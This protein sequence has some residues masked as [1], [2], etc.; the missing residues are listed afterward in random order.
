[1][2]ATFA[3]VTVT[4]GRV[5]MSSQSGP[6][7]L[8]VLDHAHALKLG[9]S[10]FVSIGNARRRHD[11]RPPAVVGG[12]PA[13]GRRLAARRALRRSAHV[14]PHGAAGIGPQAACRR[15]SRPPQQPTAATAW[16][17]RSSG[18]P[19]SSARRRSRNSSIWRC[20]SRPSRSR[21]V[22]D[23][24]DRQQRRR[25]GSAGGGSARAHGL[26]IANCM[27]PPC[28][29]DPRSAPAGRSTS[30]IPIDLTPH[31]RRRALPQRADS[32]ARG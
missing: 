6:L 1:M 2:A 32:R 23:V 8:A 27:T 9:L 14:R 28:S 15:S 31:A 17:T 12:R 7:G 13:D 18:R 29:C 3:P 16:S 30:P 26:R 5:A 19:A 25:S 20:C 22:T 10:G 4:A 24:A 21:R 11:D